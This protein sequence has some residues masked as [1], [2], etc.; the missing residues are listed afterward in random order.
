MRKPIT[1]FGL[2]AIAAAFLLGAALSG[3]QQ[4][5]TTSLA[6]PLARDK[7]AL[8]DTLT[9][10]QA[11][12]LAQQAEDNNAPSLAASV[13]ETLV[14]QITDP[15]AQTELAAAAASAAITA[16]GT[17]GAV[18]D[19][20]ATAMESGDMS[21]LDAAA[22]LAT[23]QAGA[24]AD[25]VEALSYLDPGSGI[26]DPTILEGT[27]LSAT[28]YLIA[29]VVIAAS[30]LPEGEDPTTM[31]AVEIAAFQSTPEY[32][33]AIAI[34]GQAGGMLDPG[35][36]GYDLLDQLSGMFQMDLTP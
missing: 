20:F 13:V 6:K 3:C 10:D 30:G 32:T 23:I 36:A 22:L 21:G 28:D 12:D 14:D 7:I 15:A 25:V 34:L 16:S 18:L 24:T 17:S 4:L 35:S 33:A 9:T 26:A 2:A 8:P 5:F 29:A 19:A 1:V 27:E 31:D 11:A